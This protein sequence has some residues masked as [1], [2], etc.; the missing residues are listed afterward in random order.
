MGKS[1]IMKFPTIEFVGD[2]ESGEFAIHGLPSGEIELHFSFGTGIRT[3][4]KG[5]SGGN[6]FNVGDVVCAPGEAKWAGKVFDA[7]GRVIENGVVLLQYSPEISFW[8]FDDYSGEPASV[9]SGNFD[10]GYGKPSI[11]YG[12]YLGENFTSPIW[13]KISEAGELHI[14]CTV[15]PA[16]VKPSRK[17]VKMNLSGFSGVGHIRGVIDGGVECLKWKAFRPFPGSTR[18]LIWTSLTSDPEY[19]VSES[20][21]ADVFIASMPVAKNAS[22]SLMGPDRELYSFEVLGR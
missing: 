21:N 2:K 22:Y 9:K 18:V 19:L 8:D 6:D 13:G 7:F 1:L 11:R 12:G 15:N 17:L 5:L 16:I 10:V 20:S 14:N 3:R 4:V